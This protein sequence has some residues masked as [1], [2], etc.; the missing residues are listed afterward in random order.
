MGGVILSYRF[1][2][3]PI[4]HPYWRRNTKWTAERQIIFAH[5][6]NHYY[7]IRKLSV[8]I[9]P[10]LSVMAE[11]LKIFL[12]LYRTVVLKLLNIVAPFQLIQNQASLLEIWHNNFI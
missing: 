3:M 12:N 10:R 7:I 6:L 4:I 8:P 1:T 9:M 5:K 11:V 2:Q